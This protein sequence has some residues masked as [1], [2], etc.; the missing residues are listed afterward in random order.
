M[1]IKIWEVMRSIPICEHCVCDI[2]L[3]LSI[4][5]NGEIEIK[6]NIESE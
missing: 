5:I 4:N 6:N 3:I 1:T 2:L